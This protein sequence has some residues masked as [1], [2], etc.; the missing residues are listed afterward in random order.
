MHANPHHRFGTREEA[1][2][3]L[4]EKLGRFSREP[5]TVVL[6]LPKGGVPVGAE[7]ARRLNKPFDVLL[8]GRIHVRHGGRT[9]LGAIT[10]GGVRILDSA[11][12]DRLHVT[13]SEIHAAVLKESLKLSRREKLYR[14]QRPSVEVADKTVIL[15]DDGTTS[16]ET[17]CNSIRLLRRRHVE[18]VVLALPAACRHSACSLRMETVELVTLAEPEAPETVAKWIGS[19]PET[20]I[21]YV[22]ALLAGVSDPMHR[23]P[24][25]VTQPS[26]A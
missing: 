21:D 8:V 20:S 11:T 7:I 2:R 15:T 14:D 22:R 13:Q 23:Y 25:L 9:M 16:C 12:I 4:A 3:K 1:G 17:I 10:T 5:D 19:F 6:A 24:L 18:R 26:P